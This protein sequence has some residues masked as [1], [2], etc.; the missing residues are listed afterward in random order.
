ML[1]GL[2]SKCTY[3]RQ[4]HTSAREH[5]QWISILCQHCQN[6]VEATPLYVA[7]RPRHNESEGS[8]LPRKE[9]PFL[10]NRKGCR[11]QPSFNR[12]QGPPDF[13]IMTHDYDM[14]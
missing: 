7:Q 6:F 5:P 11:N 12:N 1:A 14:L 2:M 10:K 3:L 13:D 8:K 9:M 4:L